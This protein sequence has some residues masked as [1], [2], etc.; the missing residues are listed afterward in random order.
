MTSKQI[1]D[2]YVINVP[3]LILLMDE[4]AII[5]RFRTDMHVEGD[6]EYLWWNDPN[7]TADL[8]DVMQYAREFRTDKYQYL[9]MIML[10]AGHLNSDRSACGSVQ[11][12]R[13]YD[14]SPLWTE[15]L[16]QLHTGAPADLI[17]STVT[18][19]V[20]MRPIWKCGYFRHLVITYPY[21]DNVYWPITS[22][23]SGWSNTLAEA[24][25]ISLDNASV[26]GN[27]LD[28]GLYTFSGDS[29]DDGMRR[30]N[31]IIWQ[32]TKTI[33]QPKFWLST[34]AANPSVE[35]AGDAGKVA[36]LALYQSIL[37]CRMLNAKFNMANGL[38]GKIVM[39]TP[40]AR[41]QPIALTKTSSD[42][43]TGPWISKG[44]AL[45]S[46]E[47]AKAMPPTTRF[48]YEDPPLYLGWG[49]LIS[50]V[51]FTNLMPEDCYLPHPHPTADTAPAPSMPPSASLDNYFSH[52]AT[53]QMFS[54]ALLETWMINVRRALTFKKHPLTH[55]LSAGLMG[56]SHPLLQSGDQNLSSSSVSTNASLYMVWTNIYGRSPY[57]GR[58]YYYILRTTTPPNSSDA[59]GSP[60]DQSAMETGNRWQ[61]IDLDSLRTVVCNPRSNRGIEWPKESLSDANL[62]PSGDDMPATE[63]QTQLCTNVV[64]PTALV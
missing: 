16:N 37:Y 22:D 30:H 38:P 59:A 64:I 11:Y 15:I 17:S 10:F 41:W 60:W 23:Y 53:V 19:P 13:K 50:N 18:M 34:G 55:D 3:R 36:V 54:G 57:N 29:V 1:F 28:S 12:P 25:D 63:L 9:T 39:P 62:F 5:A 42:S 31:I 49:S 26:W 8:P 21:R 7:W 44:F 20:W 32:L 52:G 6:F 40:L 48:T 33:A 27:Y 45:S 14:Y 43:G 56:L 2:W 4:D 58:R 35:Q 47:F 46:P 51:W 61:E 24:P